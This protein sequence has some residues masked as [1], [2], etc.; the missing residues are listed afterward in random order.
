MATLSNLID[1]NRNTIENILSQNFVNGKIEGATVAE[2][3]SELLKIVEEYGLFKKDVVTGKMWSSLNENPDEPIDLK[4]AETLFLT[5]FIDRIRIKTRSVSEDGD[6]GIKYKKITRAEI[7]I[8]WQNISH[9]S[10]FNSRKKMYDE[11]PAWDGKP[12]VSDY[13]KD[14]YRCN[15][16]PN[17][18]WLFITSVIGKMHDPEKNYCPF[19]FDFVGQKGT[20]KSYGL[21]RLFGKKNVRDIKMTSRREDFFVNIYDG[22]LLVANDD[23]CSWIGQGYDKMSYDEFKSLVTT[24][25]DKFSRKYGQPEEHHR[26]FVITRSSNDVRTVFSTDERRQIIF[27]INL[28]WN[29][30]RVKDLPDEYFQQVLAEA[31]DYYEKNGVYKLTDKDWL[32]VETQNIQSYN[33]ETTEYHDIADF[34]EQLARAPGQNEKFFQ[35]IRGQNPGELFFTWNGYDKWRQDNK[36]TNVDSRRFWRNLIALS[37]ARPDI[38]EHDPMPRY[39]PQ[40]T[41]VKVARIRPKSESST[42]EYADIGF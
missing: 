18:F 10:T 15:D 1:K 12:R 28:K 22:N 33:I 2:L 20:G 5:F 31:K 14:N 4:T 27:N 42:S 29:D 40:N 41:K 37:K 3:T 36:R 6:G 38:L 34:C 17:F 30:C 7:D 16:N 35:T 23:E 26:A 11:I 24:S 8:L 32:A 13:M 21:Q 9:Y 25:I 39:T 19:F